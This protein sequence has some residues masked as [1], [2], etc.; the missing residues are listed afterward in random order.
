MSIFQHQCTFENQ[1]TIIFS[2]SIVVPRASSRVLSV[3]RLKTRHT[4]KEV[5]CLAAF[6]SFPEAAVA[7]EVRD[8]H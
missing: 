1:E 7:L 2:F 3:L 4:F 6:D 8:E 5:G